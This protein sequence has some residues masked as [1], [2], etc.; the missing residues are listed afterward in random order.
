MVFLSWQFATSSMVLVKEVQSKQVKPNDFSDFSKRS[1]KADFVWPETSH[2]F[3]GPRPILH[4]HLDWVLDLSRPFQAPLHLVEGKQLEQ[5]KLKWEA[6]IISTSKMSTLT[7][8][9][10]ITKSYLLYISSII[11]RLQ[12]STMLTGTEC[13]GQSC[14]SCSA[15]SSGTASREV[16]GF[17]MK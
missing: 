8:C 2:R 17:K 11:D 9:Y 13:L 6:I 12:C 10:T 14:W 16:P 4:L 1:G 15:K 5:K 7:I 3:P